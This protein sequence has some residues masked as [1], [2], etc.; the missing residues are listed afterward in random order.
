MNRSDI[1][2]W[3]L[4][5]D[6]H[7]AFR[8]PG[9]L[10]PLR[11]GCSP[12]CSASPRSPTGPGGSP[13][14]TARTS[15]CPCRNSRNARRCTPCLRCDSSPDRR[16]APLACCSRLA[17]WS[18]R[19]PPIRGDES[20]G[21]SAPPRSPARIQPS[22]GGAGMATRRCGT[23]CPRNRTYAVA[24]QLGTC[25]RSDRWRGAHRPHRSRPGVVS[26]RTAVVGGRQCP[27]KPETRSR[28]L[29][30]LYLLA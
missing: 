20:P 22:V 19:W 7:Y 17:A 26:D 24:D 10:G 16:R 14:R 11:S 15:S 12:L 8:L 21:T 25:W 29:I 13:S 28:S 9:P 1:A 18:C 30:S 2:E 4:Q 27:R 23:M 3:V 6:P 5:R